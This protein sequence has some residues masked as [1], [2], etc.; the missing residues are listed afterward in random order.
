MIL[1]IYDAAPRYSI[2]QDNFKDH[3]ISKLRVLAVKDED[4]GML[5]CR[6]VNQKV[7]TF[8]AELEIEFVVG[9][10]DVKLDRR[11]T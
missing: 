1:L 8:A 6:A 5:T 10:L 9:K 11:P 2:T 3:V 4:A 7:S